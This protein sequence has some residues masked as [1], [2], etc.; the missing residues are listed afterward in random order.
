MSGYGNS[1]QNYREYDPTDEPDPMIDF[2]H[3]CIVRLCSWM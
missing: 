2:E 1:A 3:F